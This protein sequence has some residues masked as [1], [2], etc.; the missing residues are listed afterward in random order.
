MDKA[1]VAHL[2]TFDG[3]A[4][5]VK[6]GGK[7]GEE[8]HYFQLA[9]AGN[10]PKERAPGKDEKPED[11]DKL[12]KEFKEKTAKL[13]ERLKTEK[14]FDKWTYVVSKWTVDGL[15]KDRKDLLAEKKEEPKKEEAKT[16][17]VTPPELKTLDLKLPESKLPESIK[18]QPKLPAPPPPPP[19]VPP[20]SEAKPEAKPEAEPKPP[21]K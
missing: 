7:S 4:Y 20:K 15:L 2:D 5:T 12:D 1:V 6:I 19:P 13:E 3:F 14:A 11:K 18:V 9:V 17:D 10:F 8:N 16:P 21:L